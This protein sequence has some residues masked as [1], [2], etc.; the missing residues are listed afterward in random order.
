MAARFVTISL[1]TKRA[2]ITAPCDK[3][4]RDTCRSDKTCRDYDTRAVTKRAVVTNCAVI[5]AMVTKR[6]VVTNCAVIRAMVTKR[7]VVTNCAV[8]RA[9]VTK[10]AV[11]TNCAVIRAMVTK[12]AVVTNCAVIRAMVTKRAAER[13]PE[14]A[15]RSEA[16]H[17]LTT[18]ARKIERRET[19][20]TLF[21]TYSTE[22]WAGWPSP[23]D[24]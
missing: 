3:R 2:E 10:R 9:M 6:A 18:V 12:R 17:H 21:A 13:R 4:C 22:Q 24:R 14:R 19:E 5:R 8:I 11:V 20:C 7:A 15:L 1:M 16:H 23:G